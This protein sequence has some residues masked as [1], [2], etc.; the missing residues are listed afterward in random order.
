MGYRLPS[1][2]DQCVVLKTITVE[3]EAY[4]QPPK[5][6]QRPLLRTIEAFLAK[7]S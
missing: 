3:L 4:E 5:R 6:D 1:A 7:A 2:Y